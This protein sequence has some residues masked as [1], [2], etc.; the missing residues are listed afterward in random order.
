ML[1]MQNVSDP[2]YYTR[3]EDYYAKDKAESKAAST[4]LAKEQLRSDWRGKLI[5][6]TSR[7]SCLA[8]CRAVLSW[9]PCAK[10][11]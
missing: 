4:G 8:R 1:S 5:P 10:V 6:A 7:W 11:S 3:G 9:G 2:G